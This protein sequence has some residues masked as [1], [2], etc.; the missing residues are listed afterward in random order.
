MPIFTRR[1]YTKCTLHKVLFTNIPVPTLIFEPLVL[2]KLK[3]F[4]AIYTHPRTIHLYEV[5][6]FRLI[7]F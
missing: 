1:L 2:I 7:L 5:G 6:T 4:L 3:N